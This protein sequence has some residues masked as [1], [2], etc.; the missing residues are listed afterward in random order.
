MQDAGNHEKCRS[1]L[2]VLN[3]GAG[4]PCYY[5]V[6]WETT[7]EGKKKRRKRVVGK[8]DAMT[9]E[10]VEAI[11]KPWRLAA[12]AHRG[13]PVVVKTMGDLIAHFR[14]VELCGKEEEANEEE[15]EADEFDP[16]GRAWSTRN[17]YENVLQAWIEPRWSDVH[18]DAFVAGEV[19][20]WLG[21]LKKRP[22]RKRKPPFPEVQKEPKRLAP[23]TKSKIRSLM[24]VLFN[25]AIRWNL[26]PTNPISGP[27]RKAGVRQSS[28]RQ[29]APDILAL[30]EMRSILAELAVR[31]MALVSTDMITG[32]RRGE[33]AGLK[34]KDIDFADLLI[35][36][37]RSVVDQRTG[38]CK[39]EAS[40]KPVPIDEFTAEDLL[41]WY[42]VTPYRAPNDFVFAS[43]APRLK[44]KRGKQP[45]W[46]SKIMQYHI[47]PLIKRLGI[48]KRVAWHTFR[49][50]FTSL[51]TAHEKNVKVV[52]EL[53][54]H[55]SSKITM[56]TYA[57]AEMEAKRRAQLRI[58]K[59]LRKGEAPKGRG[60][61]AAQPKLVSTAKRRRA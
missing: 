17:R 35:H 1:K 26:F 60:V 33:L 47:Q 51:L 20:E 52:Q 44:E 29:Q 45:V 54:R 61:K 37:V 50:T 22:R 7:Q 18:L 13:G 38:R 49:H 41:A 30:G 36:V 43:D 5:F 56:D 31:E 27:A 9:L 8:V 59:G 6:W 32:L 39:T 25:H 55:A 16:D 40:A 57:Q 2:Y 19:E 23:G 14:A 46:L 15:S 28:K 3:N 11:I 10:E 12:E 42:R 53:L 58:V 4:V 48:D 24:S 21:S 34:W